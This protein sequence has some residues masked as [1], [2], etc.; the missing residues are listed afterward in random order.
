MTRFSFLLSLGLSSIASAMPSPTLANDDLVVYIECAGKEG[1]T[2]QGS[3]VLVSENGHV[4]TARHVVPDGFECLASVGNSSL[5]KR[6]LRPSFQSNS[7]NSKF[8]ALVMEF[9]R[10]TGETF[11]FASLCTVTDNLKGSNIVAKG[12]HSGSFGAP[13]STDGILSNTYIRPDGFVE[14]TAMTIN[15]KSGGPVFLQ[16]TDNIVGIIAGAEFNVQGIVSSYSVLATNA[17]LGSVNL[18]TVAGECGE[19]SRPAFELSPTYK[20]ETVEAGWVA[21]LIQDPD[22]YTNVRAGPGTNSGIVT[23]IYA[24]ETFYALPSKSTWW[25]VRSVDGISGYMHASR[26][27]LKRR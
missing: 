21:A 11:P 6:G 24:G 17:V 15:G 26:V 5:P 8:D 7:I 25:Q 13:S 23:Q 19:K 16:G 3:G 2:T 1:Q 10:N 20:E 18:L 12:F 27:L 9:G 14:T 4:L 22:G